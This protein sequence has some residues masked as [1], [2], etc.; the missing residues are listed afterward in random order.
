MIIIARPLLWLDICSGTAI[1]KEMNR[2]II[3][4]VIFFHFFLNEL[5]LLEEEGRDFGVF[6]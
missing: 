6:F 5:V 2:I 1:R 3:I 4:I